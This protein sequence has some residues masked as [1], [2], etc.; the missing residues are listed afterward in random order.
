[1]KFPHQ[2]WANYNNS[3][4]WNK[5]ILGWFPLL[6]MIPVRSQWGRY[7]LPRSN[8]KVSLNSSSWFYCTKGQQDQFTG[9][10][11]FSR[12]GFRR[13][14]SWIVYFHG[15]IPRKKWMTGGTPMT[16]S[17]TTWVLEIENIWKSCGSGEQLYTV[18]TYQFAY[19]DWP[20]LWISGC[21]SKWKTIN[22][23]TDVNV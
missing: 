8:S 3:L 6:T 5:A 2:T 4:T 23:T 1:M 15:K 20:M 9:A 12:P 13:P 22:G 18:E 21:G 16:F 14:N 11:D 7:N 17:D 10:L 19:Q